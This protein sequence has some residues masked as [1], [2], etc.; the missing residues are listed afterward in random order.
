MSPPILAIILN[1]RQPE[2]THQCINHLQALP[3]PHLDILIV[4]N[5]SAD[6]SLPYFQQHLP[7]IPVIPNPANTG[8]AHGNNLGLRYAQQHNY[9]YTLILNNDAFAEPPMLTNLLAHATPD[10]GLISPKILYEP[11]PDLLWFAGGSQAKY[12]LDLV[13]HGRGQPDTP[14]WSTRDV[15]YLLGTC[16]LVNMAALDHVGLLDESYFMYFEDLDWSLRFRQAGYRLRFVADARLHHRVAVSSGGEDTPFR[17]YHLARSGVHFWRRYAH[18]G[19]PP[20]IIAWRLLS[21]LKMVGRLLLNRQPATA[22]A[23]LRG[24]Y[25][26]LLPPQ[27]PTNTP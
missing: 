15:D 17:R 10:I 5:G 26:G 2:L 12:T 13:N 20:I 18:L 19:S 14:L 9:P 23:Y 3:Y 6:H 27:A 7:T 1:W 16:W 24:L 22:R 11:Q 25:H 4:D 21:A 8:F